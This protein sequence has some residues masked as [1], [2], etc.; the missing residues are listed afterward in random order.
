[1]EGS[2]P[3]CSV[4]MPVHNRSGL[5]RQC[6]DTL[7]GEPQEKTSFEI[8]VVDDASSDRTPSLLTE[9][10]DAIRVVTNERNTGFA[11]ACNKGAATA[12]GHYLVFLNNDTH[13]LPG[14]LDALVGYA[15]KHPNA[16][17]VGSKLLFPDNTVQHAGVV[18][19]E[20][21]NP[22][23]I[24]SGFPANHP[25]VNRSR[26]FPI[27][28]AACALF[29][30]QAFE[31]AG[32]FDDSFENGFED[33]DLCLRLGELGYEVHYCHDSVL[34]HLE[35]VTRDHRTHHANHLLYSRRW[36]HKVRPDAIQYFIEDGLFEIRWRSRFPFVL[37]VAPE[38]ATVNE[39]ERRADRMLGERAQQLYELSRE[40]VRLQVALADA[41]V[42]LPDL[43]PQHIPIFSPSKPKAVAF[44]SAAA[45][46]TLRY[47]C[48]HA[49]EQLESLGA[50]TDVSVV[51][52]TDLSHVLDSYGCFV[53]HRV[54]ANELIEHFIDHA[55]RHGC[56]VIFD[57]DDLVFQL[58][59]EEE[60]LD[61][62]DMP[63]VHRR[64][65]RDLLE[66][67]ARTMALCDAVFVA[68]EPLAQHARLIHPRVF[69]VPNTVNEEMIRLADAAVAS[70]ERGTEDVTIAYFSGTPTHDRD[71]AQAAEAV[72]A[73][74]EASPNVHFLVVG[75]LRMDERFGDFRDR[76][77]E[78]PIQ[79]WQR[80]P[81]LMADVDIN[82]APLEP[83]NAFTESKSCLK[84][85]EAALLGVP[86]VASPRHDF[87]R[88]ISDGA[89]GLF[90][91]TP[92]EWREAIGRLVA[93][94]DLRSSIGKAAF[95]DV[96]A[97]HTTR[98]N[99]QRLYDLLADLAAQ[100]QSS[101]RP[102]AINFVSSWAGI[103]AK[104][105]RK[106]A[107]DLALRGH[108]V[109]FITGSNDFPH[110][111]VLIALGADAAEDVAVTDN[112]LFRL[113]VVSSAD[114]K[115]R[116]SRLPLRVVEGPLSADGLEQLLRRVCFSRIADLT[117][118]ANSP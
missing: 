30:P 47:R 106:L 101:M 104:S 2:G 15:D 116:V 51:G 89:N 74:L 16:A 39:D 25:A 110:A 20:A 1:M 102:L 55:Q 108:R 31:K 82:L 7:L 64:I 56:P 17:V 46:D 45:G 95:E 35:M 69:V 36:A 112:A 98:A 13:P 44:L 75:N 5:T 90:A 37:T 117:V 80:L 48:D 57:T 3:I 21:L 18:I 34:V 113:C 54:P 6:L 60:T 63:D 66:P 62:V 33:V 70:R 61:L 59:A 12:T 107:D 77:T 76:I 100:K 11:G 65:F 41:E 4:I 23:H 40:N 93:S 43:A 14:W 72:L 118:T 114:E 27:V 85:L 42:E 50:T 24:Y 22:L 29:R 88:V 73:T 49:A 81:A 68:T 9:Y 10:G 58:G 99:A 86:T 91:E 103:G 115:E 111:D 78:L 26:R 87:R 84:Y 32:G 38:L 53:L 19:T 83:D 67:H 97:N 71:F 8:I 94:S 79:P 96:R 52:L 28:T 105:R 92:D 109:E